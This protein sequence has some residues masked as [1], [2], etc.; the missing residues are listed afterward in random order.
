MKKEYFFIFLIL[1]SF[2]VL[3]EV[4]GLFIIPKL[5]KVILALIILILFIV[6]KS[7]KKWHVNYIIYTIIIY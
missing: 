5:I 7:K 2:I 1:I 4:A 6:Y 3:L